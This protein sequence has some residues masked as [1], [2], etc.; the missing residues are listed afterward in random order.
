MG[1][2][3][4]SLPCPFS[5]HPL[6]IA[7][8]AAGQ[9]CCR[10]ALTASLAPTAPSHF[11]SLQTK[12]QLPSSCE[13]RPQGQVL[14]LQYSKLVGSTALSTTGKALMTLP[15]AKVVMALPS[16]PEL[17]LAPRILKL[18]KVGLKL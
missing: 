16:N 18:G 1:G 17:T 12:T 13:L 9:L 5:P 14:R 15:T 8:G 2:L 10:Q 4:L 6:H 3:H 7:C 11:P